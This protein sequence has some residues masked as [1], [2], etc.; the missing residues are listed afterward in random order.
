MDRQVVALF[1]LVLLS[2]RIYGKSECMQIVGTLICPQEPMLAGNV[3][4]D[5]KDE[6]CKIFGRTLPWETHDQMGRTWSKSDGSFMISG[7]GSDFGPFNAPDPYIIIEHK[8][9]SILKSTMVGVSDSRRKTQFALTKVFM[10]KIL[11]VGKVFLDDS[12]L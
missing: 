7:C 3:Q 10:P 4:I 12:D 5:L 11:N 6:D 1:L 9:P 2:L 8:C